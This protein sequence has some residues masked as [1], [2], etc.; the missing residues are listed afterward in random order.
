MLILGLDPGAR[1][2]GHGIIAKE[3]NQLT[4]VTSGVISFDV[5]TP[6]MKRIGQIFDSIL[7]L[8]KNTRVQEVALESLI[9]A[10][11]VQAMAK[12]A[13][14]RGAMM[15]ALHEAKFEKIFEY[16]PTLIKAAVTGGGR[17]DKNAVAQGVVLTLGLKNFDF[18][19]NDESDA[20][21][22][23][24]CHAYKRRWQH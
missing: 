18:E 12:I 22:I 20:L 19:S 7:E 16:P 8:A 5:K 4:H 11:D 13:Q 21:A 2:I 3:K 23:A 10:K 14:A 15:A 6:F 17:A 1:K 24:I 9:F